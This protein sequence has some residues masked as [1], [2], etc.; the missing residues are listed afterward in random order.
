MNVLIPLT[1]M[2]YG[3]DWW[4]MTKFIRKPSTIEA[5]QWFKD[6]DH[7]D[8][9]P[10]KKLKNT[11]IIKDVENLGNHFITLAIYPSDWL[12]GS[13]KVTKVMSNTEFNNTFCLLKDFLSND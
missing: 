1:C 12:L 11:G 9:K 2:V 13:P 4:K 5:V 3:S 6:G 7:P 8:V 10:N